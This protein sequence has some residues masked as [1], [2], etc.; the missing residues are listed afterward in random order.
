MSV[1]LEM[2]TAKAAARAVSLCMV[3]RFSCWPPRGRGGRLERDTG[4]HTKTA[5][6]RAR[7]VAVEFAAKMSAPF[8]FRERL[9]DACRLIRQVSGGLAQHGERVAGGI[10]RESVNPRRP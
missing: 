6:Q 9:K 8:T 3:T 7:G 1:R 4:Q 10:I 5:R 2:P